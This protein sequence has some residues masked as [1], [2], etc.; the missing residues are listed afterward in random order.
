[1]AS[2]KS[3]TAT[4]GQTTWRVRYR[5]Q[6]RSCSKT[7]ADQR[8]AEAFG[9]MVD[10]YGPEY[11]LDFIK[12]STTPRAKGIT[13]AACIERYA[14]L[15]QGVTKKLYEDMARLHINPVFGEKQISK[16]TPEMIQLW[17]YALGVSAATMR[18]AHSVLS[19]ALTMAV[20]RGEITTNPA[21][22]ASKSHPNGIRLPRTRPTKEPVF[23]SKDE[24]ALLLK[25]TP[26]RYKP[27]VEFLAATGCRIGEAL[28]LMPSDVNIRT[29]KVRFNKTYSRDE[30]GIFVLGTTKTESSEREIAVPPLILGQLDLSGEF[31]FTN[32]Q[33]KQLN[34]HAFRVG[35]WRK[36][37]EDS[38]LPTH[39]HPR[40]HDLRHT[41]ASWLLDAGISIHAVQKRLGHSDVM[42]TLRTYGHAAADSEDRIL[43]VLDQ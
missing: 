17:V 14:A 10:K 2:I 15:R 20:A 23:L 5:L 9:E 13:V 1:M 42:T 6:R 22:K 38:G 26:E 35:P 8:S 36:A 4:D 43:N 30:N 3:Y 25:A 31:V 28:A 7:F 16:L 29:G 11:A 32:R 21:L 39:R 24:Y 40:I 27:L 18:L 12:A 33:G 19:G 34:R 37:V 41:H